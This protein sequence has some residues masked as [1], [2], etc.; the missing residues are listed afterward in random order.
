MLIER[1]AKE[2][3]AKRQA[4]RDKEEA[5]QMQV[6][7]SKYCPTRRQRIKN[8]FKRKFGK[9]RKKVYVMPAQMPPKRTGREQRAYDRQMRA[10]FRKYHVSIFTKLI[11]KIRKDD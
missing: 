5:Q 9:K 7:Y 4:Q 3:E 2:A 6:L 1:I 8:F 11:R 10:I